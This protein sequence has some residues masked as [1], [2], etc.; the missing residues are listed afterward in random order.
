MSLIGVLRTGVS[1]MNAQANRIS[2]VAENI[3]NSGTTGYK[4]ASTEFSSLLLDSTEYGNYNSGAVQTTVRRAVNESG[5]TTFTTSKTDLAIQGNGFFV[6]RDAAG[7]SY[8]TRAG[9]FVPDG[10]TGNLV[11]AGGF[12]LMGYSLENGA[13][14]PSLNS[15]ADMVPVNV[16]LLGTQAR[17]SNAGKISG[18]L[19]YTE[20]VLPAAPAAVPTGPAYSKKTSLVTFDNVGQPVTLDIYLAKTAT[21]KWAVSFYD[22]KGAPPPTGTAL[23]TETLTFDGAGHLPAGTSTS[24]AV[25]G[26]GTVE[27]DLS[28]INQLASPFALS[29]S[30]NGSSPTTVTGAEFDT[31]GTVFAVFAD[32]TRSAAYKVPLATVPSPDNLTPRAGNVFS[33]N[34]ESGDLQVGFAN[35]EGRGFIKSGALEQSN[36]DVGTELTSMIESQ[37]VY[38]A[39]SKVFQTGNEL[40]ETLMN[41]K[42]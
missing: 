3:Q 42:R 1:G 32:G 35:L 21:D 16:S 22:S 36:V 26:G 29:G 19:P 17:P 27:I 10:D 38:T 5:P 39:N 9:N 34:S 18:N 7:G 25:P 11:N 2:T 15:V 28:G 31:D 14:N 37:S 24:V 12:T 40:L 13:P 41:L 4:R 23:K 33:A 8:M 20:A 6:V 30:A